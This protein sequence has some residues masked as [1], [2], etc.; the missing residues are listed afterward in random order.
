MNSS[1][2]KFEMKQQWVVEGV[3]YLTLSEFTKSS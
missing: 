2:V 1:N 3:M